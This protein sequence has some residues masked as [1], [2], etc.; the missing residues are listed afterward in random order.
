MTHTHQEI[1]IWHVQAEIL[2]TC[3][4]DRQVY[5]FLAAPSYQAVPFLSF[6]PWEIDV[7][8]RIYLT[9]REFVINTSTFLCLKNTGK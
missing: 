7:S 3:I 6:L 5:S 2:T 8:P 4:R 9:L 1:V